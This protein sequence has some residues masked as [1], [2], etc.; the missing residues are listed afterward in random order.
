LPISKPPRTRG[1]EIQEQK[2]VILEFAHREGITVSRL[3]EMPASAAIGK[4]INQLF[5]QVA[6][7]DTL[8]V[9]ELSRIGRSVGQIVRTVDALIKGKVRFIAIKEGIW[10]NQE[11]NSQTQAM[12]QIV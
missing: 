3:I 4:R 2:R 11:R 5:T 7:G 9:S 1:Q 12:G 10:L 8:I 6:S